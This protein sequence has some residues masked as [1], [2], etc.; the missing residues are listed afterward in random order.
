LHTIDLDTAEEKVLGDVRRCLATLRG[1]L[2]ASVE[3]AETGVAA[4]SKLRTEGYEELNQIQHE[5]AALCAVRWLLAQARAPEGTRWEWNPRQ[6]GDATEPDIRG[7]LNVRVLISGEVTTSARPTGVIDSRMRSTL[8]KL[9]GMEGA[10]FYFVLS[11]HMRK[12]AETKVRKAGH[13]IVVVRLAD[14]VVV[15]DSGVA[16]DGT[17]WG[18]PGSK[19]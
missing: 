17:A 19:L 8:E 1:L 11:G 4:L 15:S 16:A 10:R 5:Y 12:R 14:A 6:T 7:V 18:A 13:D 9:A 3:T 2:P